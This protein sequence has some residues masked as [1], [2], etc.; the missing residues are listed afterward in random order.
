MADAEWEKDGAHK[1]F[2]FNDHGDGQ[3]EF[4]LDK[5]G[6]DIARSDLKSDAVA[7]LDVHSEV[8]IWIGKNASKDERKYAMEHVH[9]YLKTQGRP[10]W[11]PITR[12][13][14]GGENEVFTKYLK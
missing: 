9:E 11:L 1:L 2:H 14:E 7:V 5:E 3:H 4:I 12:L 6:N 13:L 8:F 10:L